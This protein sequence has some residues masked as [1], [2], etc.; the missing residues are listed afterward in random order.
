MY[1][2]LGF[3]DPARPD[4][5]CLLCK[6]LYG[7]K[8]APR[9]WYQR[10]AEYVATIGFSHS[11]SDNSLFTYCRGKDTAFI[12][13]Y[14][15]DIILTASSNFL[16][17]VSRDKNSLFMFQSSYA[18]DILDRAGMSQS[19][20]GNLKDLVV[21][22][23]SSNNLGGSLPPKI[24]NLKIKTLMDLSMNQ[25]SNGI[26]RQIRGLQN[27]VHLSLR[28]NKLQGSIPDSM[29][30]MVGL[31]FLDLSHNNISGIIP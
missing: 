4:H 24:G 17:L 5:V 21:L 29:S 8:Q 6:S 9:A 27:L 13:L 28:H 12:L 19:S 31:E 14:V 16:R 1:Q 2:P 15:D 30:N 10:F 20:L 18:E 11:T 7:L 23:L 26:P 3:R 22:D 25:F